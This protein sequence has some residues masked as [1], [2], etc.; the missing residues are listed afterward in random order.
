MGD[1]LYLWKENG[2]RR[3]PGHKQAEVVRMTHAYWLQKAIIC[4]VR[5]ESDSC[6]KNKLNDEDPRGEVRR[7]E[8]DDDESPLQAVL[9][10]KGTVPRKM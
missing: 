9:K 3:R 8:Y 2:I 10:S 5:G 4:D 6:W 1:R 7:L